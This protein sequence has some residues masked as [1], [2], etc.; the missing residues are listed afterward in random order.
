MAVKSAL[1]AGRL[2]PPGRFLVLISVRGW[3]DTKVIVRLKGLGQLK[4]SM[5]SSGIELACRIMVQPTTLLRASIRSVQNRIDE[6][7]QYWI[8]CMDRVIDERTEKY[9]RQIGDYLRRKEWVYAVE[10]GLEKVKRRLKNHSADT[11]VK[12]Y[13]T[14]CLSSFPHFIGGSFC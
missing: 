2:L 13:F 6:R 14:A 12:F 3:V 1:H 9:F 8:N 7:K 11:N 4:N 5:T 10:T